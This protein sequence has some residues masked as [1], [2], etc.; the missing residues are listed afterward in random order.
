MN[1]AVP[2]AESSSLAVRFVRRA[3]PALR[4]GL[5]LVGLWTVLRL[6]VV[7]FQLETKPAPADLAAIAGWGLVYDVL[8]AATAILPALLFV[9]LLRARWAYGPRTRVTLTWLCTMVVTF[10]A[11]VQY[12]FFD[13]YQ[14][15]YNHLALDYLAYPTEVFGNILASYNVPLVLAIAAAASAGLTWLQLRGSRPIPASWPLRDRLLSLAL[16]V[17]LTALVAGAWTVLPTPAIAERIANE[18]ARSGWPELARAFFT[19]H[20]DYDAYYTVLPDAEA[21]ARVARVIGQPQPARGLVRHFA[22]SRPA[23]SPPLDVAIVLEESLGSEFSARF[24]S[25]RNLTPELDRWSHE[26]V[27]LRNLM[28]TGNRTVRGLEAI[29]CSFPPLPG[30]AIVKRDEST[31]LASVPAVLRARGYQTTFVYGGRGVFDNLEPFLTANGVDTFIDQSSFAADAYRTVWGVADEY[32][33]DELLARQ[34]EAQRSRRPLFAGALTVSN[35][36][37]FGLPPGR[38]ITTQISK[39]RRAVQYADWAIG[40]YLTQAKAAGILDHTVVLI[41]GDHGARVYG[42]PVIPVASYRIPAVILVPDAARRDTTID[43]L[44]SQVDLGPTVLSLAGI[45]YDAP[46][47]GHDLLDRPRLGGRAFVNHNRSIGLLTDTALAVQEIQRTQRFYSRLDP[48]S[49]VLQPA[50]PSDDL[51]ELARDAAAIYQTAYRVYLT[52]GYGLPPAPPPPR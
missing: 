34:V 8:A 6:L 21:Q 46:F 52:H 31:D 4:F 36:K 28:A 49:D 2:A 12:F 3:D 5:L 16:V 38:I 40:R 24:S 9:A 26:G 1:V 48:T 45:E 19:S 23:G 14:A 35:H 43:V 11:A 22:A 29:M 17:T 18:S 33:L 39:R 47:F 50:P 27:A 25:K 13:E 10:D 42:A 30:D 37:P 15:R 32:V 41:V 20:L 7:L 51:R 44:A